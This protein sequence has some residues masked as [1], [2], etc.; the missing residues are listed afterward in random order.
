MCISVR[1]CVQANAGVLGG[2]RRL[3]RAKLELQATDG[4]PTWVL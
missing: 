1:G 2:Q 3:M 4:H